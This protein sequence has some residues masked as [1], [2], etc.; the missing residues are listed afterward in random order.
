MRGLYRWRQTIPKAEM[1]SQSSMT[2]TGPFA[3]YRERA[4]VADHFD[5]YVSDGRQYRPAASALADHFDG[6]GVSGMRGCATEAAR[7]VQQSGANFRLAPSFQARSEARPWQLAITPLAM[8]AATWNQI[9]RGLQQRVRLLEAILNDFLGPQQLLKQRVIPSEI[10]HSNPEFFRAYHGLPS[11]GIRLSMTATDLAR[12]DDGSWWVTGDRTRAPSGLG[13]ALENRVITSRIFPKLIRNRNVVRL[14]SFFASVQSHFDSMSPHGKE[15]P[16]VA[17]LTPGKGSYRYVEDAYLAR[18]LGYTLVHGRDLAVRGNRLN[19]KTLGGLLP[20]DVLWRHISDQRCDPLELNPDSIQGVTGMMQSVRAGNVAV[21]NAL[22]SVLV[23]S[24]A[25]LPFLPAA[26]KFFFGEDLHLPSIATYWCGGANERKHVLEHLD[27]LLI[28]PAFQILSEPMVD[29]SEL[30]SEERER[31]VARIKRTPEKY[32]AQV[33]PVRSTTPVWHQDELHPWHVALRTFQ[34]STQDGVQVMPGGLVRVGPDAAALDNS[35][36][37]GRLGQDCWVVADEYTDQE[38]TRTRSGRGTV[39]LVRSGD[40]LPSRVAENLF[41]LG[42][43]SERTEFIARLMRTTLNRIS[44]EQ[45]SDQNADLRRLVAAL[46]ATGQVEPDH[47]IEEW[48]RD[49]PSLDQ[50]LPESVFAEGRTTGMRACIDDMSD[51]ALS[52]TDRISL[53]A[54][55]IIS[56]LETH[57]RNPGLE[58]QGDLVIVIERLDHLITDLLAFSGLTHE[59]VMR[60]HGWRFLDLGRRIERAFQTAELLAATLV[61]PI[62]KERLLIESVLQSTDSIMTYRSRYLQQFLPFAAIDLLVTDD[63]NPRSLA[64]QLAAIGQL[65]EAL[66]TGESQV[67]LGEDQRIARDLLHRVMMA[68]PDQL[69]ECRN[70]PKSKRKTEALSSESRPSEGESRERDSALHRPYL[71]QLLGHLVKEL[72]RLSDAISARYLIHTASPQTLTGRVK[73]LLPKL[74]S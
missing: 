45:E 7:L 57:L 11:N 21:A 30:S 53:D 52:I 34:L 12:N 70:Y 9:E 67:N 5:E 2:A 32:V 36:T 44:G 69:S 60:A 4:A 19:L 26:S 15:N 65:L 8:D 10:L 1:Q 61:E 48:G 56:Q 18:Y 24:P 22:G 40:E 41:W 31:W 17:I 73:T 47:V 43:I 72:P 62:G 55:R 64:F 3:E 39:K 33:R 35:P 42:R 23:Q 29:M 74:S 6:L 51:K 28:R 13:Y 50:V 71:K 58:S 49:L 46:A 25:L 16:R 20:I 66:P 68:K 37:T 54:F 59:S 38:T 27:R 14:A 63:S